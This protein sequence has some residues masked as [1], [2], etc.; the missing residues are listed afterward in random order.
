MDEQ[1]TT[2]SGAT[3]PRDG[4][5]RAIPRIWATQKLAFCNGKSIAYEILAEIAL[6]W[7]DR[8]SSYLPVKHPCGRDCKN[9]SGSVNSPLPSD[10]DPL[11]SFGET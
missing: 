6:D 1:A 2:A 11:L 4:C 9:V 7:N 3:G 5:N 10:R 8:F